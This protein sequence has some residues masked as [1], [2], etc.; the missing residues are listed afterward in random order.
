MTIGGIQFDEK[1]L[2]GKALLEACKIKTS[3]E[4]SAIGAYRGFTLILSFDTFSKAFQLTLKNVLSHSITLGSDV[5]G[6]I[7]RIDNALSGLSERME[8]CQRSL[9]DLQRQVE[10]AR[11]EVD[12]P[13]AQEQELA[14]KAA[15]LAELDALLSMEKGSSEMLDG[16]PE[17]EDDREIDYM[18]R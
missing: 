6:N 2:A 1:E 7:S 5:Y 11:M 8:Q 15:R 12:K 14:E 13:F 10:E 18:S 9:E 17:Q 16:E 4:A 3:P